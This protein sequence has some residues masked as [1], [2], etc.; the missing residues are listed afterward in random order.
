M[1]EQTPAGTPHEMVGGAAE[2]AGLPRPRRICSTPLKIA[3]LR[4]KEEAPV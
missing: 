3:S 1:H 2:G 4:R